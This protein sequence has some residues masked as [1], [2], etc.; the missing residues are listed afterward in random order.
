MI[1]FYNQYIQSAGTVDLT[2][3]SK[4]SYYS[5]KQL[6]GQEAHKSLAYE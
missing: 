2:P 5:Y 6:N 1:R 4:V 3:R